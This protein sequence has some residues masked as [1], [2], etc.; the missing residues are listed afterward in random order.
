[1]PTAV[2]Q[3]RRITSHTAG[4]SAVYTV[5]TWTV[6]PSATARFVIENDTD[7]I[8]LWTTAVTTTFNYNIAGN[9]WDT[10]TWAVRPVAVGAGV[11]ATQSYSITPDFNKHSRHSHIYSIRG[12]N[13]SAIDLFDIA[14]AATGVWT[15][16]IPY[17]NLNPL[18]TTG[19]CVSCSP[20]VL[21][22]RYFYINHNGLQRFYRFDML[23]RTLE[24]WCF[25]RYAQGTAVVGNKMA[26]G[27][28]VDGTTKVEFI[29]AITSSGSTFFNSLIQR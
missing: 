13:S 24:P 11:A 4:P 10:A 3:R 29:F 18:F 14:G 21:G 26:S 20:S 5:A 6:N 25:M 7:K 16:A 15:G 12:A 22:G 28:F 17:G 2:G 19:T 23:N 1:M 27:V 9:T 8:L